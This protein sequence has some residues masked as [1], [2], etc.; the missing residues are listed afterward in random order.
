MQ[1]NLKLFELADLEIT[2]LKVSTNDL[3]SLFGKIGIQ[4]FDLVYR[5]SVPPIEPL[6]YLEK[7]SLVG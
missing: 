3:A 5:S 1:T 6:L 7:P 4:L 2:I